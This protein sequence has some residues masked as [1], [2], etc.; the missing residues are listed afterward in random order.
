ML[1]SMLFGGGACRRS[2]PLYIATKMSNIRKSSFVVPSADTYARAAVRHIG[3]ESR[4]TP[5]LPHSVMWFL[6]SF[7]SPF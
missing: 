3:H 5:Y 6:I 7:P 1:A 2:A 4:C